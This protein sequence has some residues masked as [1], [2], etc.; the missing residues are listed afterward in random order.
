MCYNSTNTALCH[1]HQLSRH[2]DSCQY[3]RLHATEINCFHQLSPCWVV[4]SG[5][6]KK[7]KNFSISF[8]PISKCI[9]VNPGGLGGRNPRFWAGG[10]GGSQ[11]GS[12]RRGRVV[13]Y[14]LYLIMN[15]KYVRKWWLLQRNRIICPEIAVNSQFLPGKSIFF[16]NLP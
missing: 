9:R 14:I 16:G 10:R 12:W 6:E 7:C 13:K 3:L 1:T 4:Q 11:G 5:G 2:S 15:R 8:K